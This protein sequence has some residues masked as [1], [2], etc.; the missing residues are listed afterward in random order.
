MYLHKPLRQL[1]QFAH[2]QL[3]R[4]CLTQNHV[5]ANINICRMKKMLLHVKDRII[6]GE[7][8][9]VNQFQ[10]RLRTVKYN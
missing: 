3:N 5:L 8:I 9:T 10:N 6:L 1:T 4:R 2:W 7:L